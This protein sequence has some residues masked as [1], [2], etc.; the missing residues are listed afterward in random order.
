VFSQ[1]YEYAIWFVTQAP[2]VVLALFAVP[3]ALLGR[4]LHVY[5]RRQA[6]FLFAIPFLFSLLAIVG[7][8]LMTEQ[9]GQSRT[10][11]LFG[12]LIVML[13]DV[14]ILIVGL[15]DLCL[16]PGQKAFAATREMQKAASI[17][18]AHPVELTVDYRGWLPISLSIKDDTPEGITSTPDMRTI[19]IAPRKRW[20]GSHT[21]SASHRGPYSLEFVY[22]NVRSAL[23]FWRK[24]IKIPCNSTLHVYPDMK[25]LAEYAILARSNRLSLIGVRRTRKIGQDSDFERLRDYTLDDN[26]KFIDW[27]S[28][29]RRNKLTVKDFQSDQSQ[30][31]VFMLDCGRMMTNTH[32]GLS[33]VDY[34]LNSLLMLSHVAL[35][36]GDSVGLV[37]F[38]DK[39]DRYVPPRS[40]RSQLNQLLHAGFDRFPDL[41]ESRFD[42]AFL[43][44]SSHLRKRSLVVLI[45][46]I[47]DQVN[48]DQITSYLGNLQQRHLP[49]LVLLRDHRIFDM[50]DNPAADPDVLFRSAAAA[51][52]LTWREQ[53]LHRLRMQGVLV[54]DAFPEQMTSPMINEYLKAKAKHLL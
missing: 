37:C 25:Q 34:G 28:T 38:S 7:P 47:I 50:A 16:L 4:L 12:T 40:G 17:G 26:Y 36:Q 21:I 39:V 13:I 51:S 10:L 41:V 14:L 22:L 48:A 46:S 30:R 29:A 20:Q 23:G 11:V 8:G 35:S 5:P 44:L 24:N 19:S 43:H 53:V 18:M 33:L 3:F 49:L 1:L 32:Q 2:W 9:S 31:V 54:V 45:T 15:V 6:A 52:I 27:R 42:Q